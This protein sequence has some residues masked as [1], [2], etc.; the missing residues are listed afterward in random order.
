MRSRGTSGRLGQGLAREARQDVGEPVGHLRDE[1]VG[2]P[3]ATPL[4]VDETS[5]R[6]SPS[7]RSRSAPHR[8]SGARATRTSPSP[9]PLKP[10]LIEGDPGQETR[11]DHLGVEAESTGLVTAATD[12]LKD[13]GLA[14]FEEIDTSCCYALQDKVWAHGPG[15]E[16]WKVYA[17]KD[18]ADTLGKSTET[19]PDSCSTTADAC[20]GATVQQP[21]PPLPPAE[22]WNTARDSYGPRP[23]KGFPPPGRP[24]CPVLA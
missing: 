7:T 1:Q 22:A 24:R 3:G 2:D 20:C 14:T 18:D 11:L 21:L 6:R 8:P 5:K 4:A 23:D 10:V 17:V 9:N 15:R 12:R 19:A 16:L 13:A